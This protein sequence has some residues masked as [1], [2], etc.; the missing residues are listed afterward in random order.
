MVNTGTLFRS[1]R[2]VLRVWSANIRLRHVKLYY[3]QGNEAMGST[4]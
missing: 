4:P 2:N 1:E 3:G